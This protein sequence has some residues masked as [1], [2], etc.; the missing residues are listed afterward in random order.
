MLDKLRM[1]QQVLSICAM[2][3][4]W[5]NPLGVSHL[6]AAEPVVESTNDSE[7]PRIRPK[8]PEDSLKLFRN[9]PGF[10]VELVAAEPLIRDPVAIEFD[11]RGRMFVVEAPEYNQYGARQEFAG[12]AAV[13]RLVDVDGDGIYDRSTVFVDS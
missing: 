8:S 1:R 4:G 10:R 11:A 2:A 13:K 3:I 5:A 9:S 7:V 6:V 12:H